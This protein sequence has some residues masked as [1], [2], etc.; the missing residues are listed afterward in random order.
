MNIDNCVAVVTGGASGLGEAVVRMIVS[1]GGKVAIL[2]LNEKM[3]EQLASEL[4]NR[5]IFKKTDVT[6]EDSVKGAINSAV[7]VFGK[8]DVAVN[9]AGVGDAQKV[10]GKKGP[11]DLSIFNK[12]VQIN[13]IGSFNVLRL[14]VEKMVNNEPNQSGERGVIIN[15]SSGAA[16]EGQIGQAAYSASKGALISM[17][18]PIA[19]ELASHGIRVMTVAPG[20]F[21]T[22]MF[23]GVPESLRKALGEMVPF[24]NRMGYPS[25]FGQLVE[26]IIE[27]PMLNGSTIRLDGAMRMQAK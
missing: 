20:L 10:F 18:L 25:E 9:C 11:H 16:Y 3:G 7:K 15:T 13:L 1:K 8:I 2:D 14:A 4:G 5:V 24:P 19:R 22:P 17:T 27:N 26:S 21:E 6:G 23:L 12:V